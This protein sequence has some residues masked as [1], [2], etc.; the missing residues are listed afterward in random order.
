VAELVADILVSS[1]IDAC[2]DEFEP[3]RANVTARIKGRTD[4]KGLVFSAHLDT[5]PIGKQPWDVPPFGGV[6]SDGRMYGRGA[7]DMKSGLAAM[8]ASALDVNDQRER[9]DGDLILAFTAGE[10]SACLGARRLVE[11]NTLRGADAILVS[12]PTSLRLVTAEKGAMWVRAIASG[13]SGHVSG[14]AS[15]TGRGTNAIL[16]MVEFLAS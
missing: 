12:E 13:Q 14:A 16:P 7:A 5:V 15:S 11:Q 2:L 3:G 8:I 10:S 1:G 4:I 9:L 6:I